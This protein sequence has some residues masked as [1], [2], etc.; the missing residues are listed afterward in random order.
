MRNM[1][2]VYLCTMLCLQW[3]QR[4][5]SI[6]VL[7]HE[8]FPPSSIPPS[9]FLLPSLPPSPFPLS[10]FSSSL[11]TLPLSLLFHMAVAMAAESTS[12]S[13]TSQGC[14]H[15]HYWSCHPPTAVEQARGSSGTCRRGCRD[16]GVQSAGN[17]DTSCET[18][19]S[20]WRPQATKTQCETI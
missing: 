7:S 13:E 14:C 17:T 5:L 16:P 9:L 15:D 8:V 12:S 10:H 18:S 20:T 2:L 19:C 1:R 6:S 3:L 4:R 11:P